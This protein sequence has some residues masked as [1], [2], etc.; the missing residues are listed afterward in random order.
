LVSHFP[1][2]TS[3]LRLPVRG[4]TPVDATGTLL[5]PGLAAC[6]AGLMPA[7]TLG[8]AEVEQRLRTLRRRLNWVTAQQSI[9]LGA[10]FVTLLVSAVIVVGLRA[11]ASTFRVAA[12]TGLLLVVIAAL[13]SIAYARRRWLDL[14]ETARV[15]DGRA[16][17]T[18]RLATLVDLRLRP[19]PSRLAPVL[20]AQALALGGRWQARQI[21][22]RR[23][24][25][26]ILV[27]IASLLMLAGTGLI[28]R[29]S[30]PPPTSTATAT[31]VELSAAA[32]SA[33]QR[34]SPGQSGTTG[35][36]KSPTTLIPGGDFSGHAPGAQAGK[37]QSPS[38]SPSSPQA[39]TGS[40]LTDRLQQT[41]HHA[42]GGD[43]P[44]Q[45][46]QLASGPGNSSRSDTT[47]NTD[48]DLPHD[49]GDQPNR[50]TSKKADGSGKQK[51]LG[52]ATGGERGTQPQGQANAPQNF[53]GSSPRAGEGS[54]PRGLLE[55]NA[56]GVVA[57]Q[58]GSKRFKL[59]I[60]SFLHA[61]PEQAERPGA[62]A[63][64]GAAGSASSDVALNKRQ[65]ADD[66][67]RKTEVP[68]EYEDL[69]RRVYSRAEP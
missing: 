45:R 2:L 67:L 57:G 49:R 5:Y 7:I 14:P 56:P 39:M 52:H 64:A 53:Q 36:L 43:T 69:V 10:S 55:P 66:A 40:S 20:V 42:F 28:T 68:P 8:L 60:T 35:T 27:F 48:R 21:A 3:H 22:P 4:E 62:G 13:A 58:E 54:N 12:C 33:A 34:D 11:S 44:E 59:A 46:T 47:T 61:A 30:V 19:R 29:P 15:V 26:S 51:D 9:Y 23:I 37:G 31:V 50:T 16:Q 25:R 41:I 63:W 1:L 32:A 65:L 6:A 17:L 24:P 18:D 38:L